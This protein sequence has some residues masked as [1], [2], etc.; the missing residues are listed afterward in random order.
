MC[1]KH[2]P[3]LVPCFLSGDYCQRP[4]ATGAA[5]GAAAVAAAAAGAAA[6]A[7]AASF[8]YFSP[9]CLLSRIEGC[10]LGVISKRQHLPLNVPRNH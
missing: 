8:S 5:A 7:A 1:Q 9:N 6:A 10:Y 2:L 3:F 4:I